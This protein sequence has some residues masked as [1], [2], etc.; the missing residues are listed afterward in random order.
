MATVREIEVTLAT[1]EDNILDSLG[2]REYTVKVGSIGITPN[3][4][5]TDV[6]KDKLGTATY[7]GYVQALGNNGNPTNFFKL[8]ISREVAESTIRQ[9]KYWTITRESYKAECL[10][11]EIRVQDSR[12]VVVLAVIKRI[13]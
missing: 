2:Y 4:E 3:P 9:A 1:L 13:E 10:P 11:V 6:P 12:Y 8:V 5:V 7:Q